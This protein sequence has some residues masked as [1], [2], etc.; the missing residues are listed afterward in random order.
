MPHHVQTVEN[1][2]LV[3]TYHNSPAIS[4]STVEIIA[5]ARIARNIGFK[6]GMGYATKRGLPVTL[7]RLAMQLEAV[8]KHIE[9]DKD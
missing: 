2:F 3:N 8:S 4:H 1:G 6:A 7:M 9:C 5:A